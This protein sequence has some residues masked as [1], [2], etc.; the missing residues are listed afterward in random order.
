MPS[1]WQFAV[2]PAQHLVLALYVRDAAG[3]NPPVDP[4]MPPLRPAVAARPGIIAE[5]DRATIT[6]QWAQWWQHLWGRSTSTLDVLL[7]PDDVPTPGSLNELQALV[8]E[9]FDE[10]MAA[11][12]AHKHDV[13]A[14]GRSMSLPSQTP[15]APVLKHATRRPTLRGV[16]PI[17]LHVSVLPAETEEGWHPHPGHVVVTKSLRADTAAYQQWLQPIAEELAR[18]SDR[19]R[20]A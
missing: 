20:T 9:L 18:P 10:A 14:T 6:D 7:M 11:C 5:S 1:K 8:Q 15:E 4:A 16:R 3:L 12:T 2:G 19:S 17:D 13:A